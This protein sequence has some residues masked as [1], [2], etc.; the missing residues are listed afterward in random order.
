MKFQKQYINGYLLQGPYKSIGLLEVL[1]RFQKI[2]IPLADASAKER[3]S[4]LDVRVV[5]Q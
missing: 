2:P 5:V 3:K 1:L 4:V